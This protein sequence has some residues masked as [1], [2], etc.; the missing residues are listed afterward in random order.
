MFSVSHCP[1]I[2]LLYIP[3]CSKK[4]WIPQRTFSLSQDRTE[5][6]VNSL[7][8]TS[9][10]RVCA[11]NDKEMER[12]NAA[13]QSGCVGNGNSRNQYAVVEKEPLLVR[14]GMVTGITEVASRK[15]I[16]CSDQGIVMS[17]EPDTS[18]QTKGS[19]PSCNNQASSDA[20]NFV[21][22]TDDQEIDLITGVNEKRQPLISRTSLPQWTDE[23]LDV[24][25]EMEFD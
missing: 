2:P 5:G 12:G 19:N 6:I 11:H 4:S 1:L 8:Q 23:Q 24:L 16:I 3:D 15:D 18:K 13:P 10:S 20:A 7:R 22:F 21:D 14:L 9:K 25:M 17:N